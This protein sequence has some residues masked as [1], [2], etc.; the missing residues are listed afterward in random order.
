MLEKSFGKKAK[1]DFDS[2]RFYQPPQAEEGE[3]TKWIKPCYYC[4]CFSLIEIFS[5]SNIF[6]LFE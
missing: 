6:H 4:L 2:H 1:S 5:Q 3:K